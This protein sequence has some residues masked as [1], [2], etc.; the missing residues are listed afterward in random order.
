MFAKIRHNNLKLT[1]NKKLNSVQKSE[2]SL[3]KYT[4]LYNK[5]KPWPL[6]ISIP[7]MSLPLPEDCRCHERVGENKE[8]QYSKQ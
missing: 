1:D 6:Y 2:N 7:C 3:E 4:C 8:L 5:T